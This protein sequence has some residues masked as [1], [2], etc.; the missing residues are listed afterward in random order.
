MMSKEDAV[1]GEGAR[2]RVKEVRY[3]ERRMKE[4]LPESEEQ[5]SRRW[6]FP[7]SSRYKQRRS[8]CCLS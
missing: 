4:Y 5:Q 1:K 8:Q 6:S 3:G 2:R 7:K